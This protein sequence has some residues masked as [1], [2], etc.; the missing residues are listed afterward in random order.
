MLELRCSFS[1]HRSFAAPFFLKAA[2]NAPELLTFLHGASTDIS[3]TALWSSANLHQALLF[4]S[5]LL[6]YWF[7]IPGP[8]FSPRPLKWAVPNCPNNMVKM[9]FPP[10]SH[11]LLL[12]AITTVT[13]WPFYIL[14]LLSCLHSSFTTLLS[15]SSC[16]KA[17]KK[18]IQN[19]ALYIKSYSSFLI[20]DISNSHNLSAPFTW[21]VF[22]RNFNSPPKIDVYLSL[23]LLQ[24]LCPTT[25]RSLHH[26]ICVTHPG[27]IVC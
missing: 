8:Y 12:S 16:F 21:I 11:H 10:L 18:K 22:S 23:L 1:L 17:I 19:L 3:C 25:H 7:S 9:S 5:S 14:I 13:S 27:N 4:L 2:N 24:S 15:S 6:H 20:L 26:V